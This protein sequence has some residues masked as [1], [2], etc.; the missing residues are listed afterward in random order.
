MIVISVFAL[1]GSTGAYLALK[2]R[3]EARYIQVLTTLNEDAAK[4]IENSALLLGELDAATETIESMTIDGAADY[5][6]ERTHAAIAAARESTQKIFDKRIVE[7]VNYRSMYLHSSELPSDSELRF[8]DASARKT[9]QDIRS[10]M[11]K[12][13]DDSCVTVKA[14]AG[15]YLYA[16][17]EL[18][19]MNNLT[20]MAVSNFQDATAIQRLREFSDGTKKLTYHDEINQIFGSDVT[21]R[22]RLATDYLAAAYVLSTVD[23]LTARSEEVMLYDR[24][25][26][27]YLAYME[28]SMTD[29]PM[30]EI[31]K[32]DLQNELTYYALLKQANETTTADTRYSPPIAVSKVI[33]SALDVHETSN[34]ASLPNVSTMEELMTWLN[35]KKYLSTDLKLPTNNISYKYLNDENVELIVTDPI[36][37]KTHVLR[38]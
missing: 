14:I 7:C 23:Y 31:T 30:H 34:D 29:D 8:N 9:I 32:K 16:I 25:Q 1:G 12:K 36:K 28:T 13:E 21:D 20:Q 18:D 2:S 15:S 33:Y 24:A 6:Y 19:G 38:R 4:E 11:K 10:V 3:A 17:D 22:I 26:D 5:N 27:D 35:E 37:K